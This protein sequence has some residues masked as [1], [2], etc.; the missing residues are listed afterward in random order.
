MVVAVA[1]ALEDGARAVICASTGNT[2]ASAAA[3]G[4]AAGLEVVVV[5]PRGRIAAGK[6]LQ[7]Q[8]AGARVVAVEGGFDDALAVVREL[9]DDPDPSAPV[10]LVNSVNPYRLDGQKT[11]AFE[12]MRGPRRCARLPR[13][14]GRQ[15]R[16]HHGLLDGLHGVPRGR[17]RRD[18]ARDARLPGRGR[19]AARAAASPSTTRRRSRPR[20]ASARPA[21]GELGAARPRRVGRPH[22]RG[23][24][25]RRS[26][27]RTGTSPATRAS[28][29]SLPARHR[30]PASASSPRTAASTPARR[31]CACSP[32]TGSRTP[33]PARRSRARS[34][35][36]EPTVEGVRQRARL[37]SDAA[38]GGGARLV[39]RSVTVEVPATSANLGAGFDALALALD[40]VNTV[41]VE[42]V[43]G[44]RGAAV[45]RRASRA[46]AP[47]GS[48]PTRRTGS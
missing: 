48:R 40:L 7:A 34:L 4:A 1:K 9:A 18:G 46:R 28:S 2:S 44:R 13:H 29:A 43:D 8:A 3:Y 33:T 16:Q 41:H 15:R 17:A 10:T 12:V 42:A 25:T 36:A 22:R 32:G 37:V 19:G 20:S 6:L 14:P 47:T 11:A 21:S 45:D 27:R 5:L 24:A 39:G 35:D 38:S 31:S 26:S 23:H 30:W